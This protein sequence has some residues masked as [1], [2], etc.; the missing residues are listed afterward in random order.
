[1]GGA[2][3]LPLFIFLFISSYPLS[4]KA[5]LTENYYEKTC[6]QFEKIMQDIVSTK[7]MDN[8]TT[9][10]A[11]LRL[12]FHDCMVEGCDSSAFITSTPTNKA[13]R[14]HDN[15]L[16]IG[17]DAFDLI[18]KAKT[19]LE[20]ACP[21]IVSCS[22]IL[23]LATRDLITM[24]GGPFVHVRLG[25][26]DGLVSL[27]SRV[28]LINS[29]ATV[30]EQIQF[31]A[32]RGFSVQEM[33]ALIGAHTI[34]FAHCK[35]FAPRLFNY[36]Q[37]T[38]TDPAFNPRFATT[39]KSSCGNFE[40]NPGMAIFFD[41]ISPGRFDNM[42][43]QNMAR[44]LTLLKSD[45]DLFQDPRTKPF[46]L[47]YASDQKAFFTDFTNAMEKLLVL[48]IKTGHQGEVRRRCDSFNNIKA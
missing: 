40:K 8:P 44:G 2:A 1:M 38:P 23:A 11:T 45:N 36:S 9:A 30:S 43:Y 18:V 41:V 27:A 29:T 24:V 32:S 5:I 12:L 48:N 17:G 6:P 4:S 47:K 37:A 19:A 42:F 10:A 14:E 34:G 28:D 15:N 22:D 21:G 46:V 35:E 31:F 3:A 7:Q 20:L 13:E 25:R 39:L 33:V 16:S 26:K